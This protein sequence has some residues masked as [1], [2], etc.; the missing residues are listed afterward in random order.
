MLGEKHI[1]RIDKSVSLNWL[2]RLGCAISC[3]NWFPAI[4][5]GCQIL[6]DLSYTLKANQQIFLIL[7]NDKKG[8][9]N[10]AQ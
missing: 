4:C 5:Y 3:L 8:T 9:E 1:E 7:P 2:F 10:L 6:S